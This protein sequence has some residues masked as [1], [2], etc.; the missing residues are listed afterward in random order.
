MSTRFTS[1]AGID[2][3]LEE[4]H[5]LPL[6]D[7][8]VVL[9]RGCRLDPPGLEGLTRLTA[10]MMRRGP[11]GVGAELFD[12][13]LDALGS[14]LATTVA[15]ESTRLSGTVLQRNL[16]PFLRA[17]RDVLTRPALRKADLARLRRRAIA[18]VRGLRDHDRALAARAFRGA[19]FGAH[20]YARP[21]WG[22]EASLARITLDDVRAQHARLVRAGHLWVGFAGAVREGDVRPWVDDALGA[23]P[24]G[25]EPRP[26][27]GAVRRPRGRRVVL[28]D[29]PSRAQTQLYV[30]AL[31]LRAGDPRSTAATVANTGFGGTFTSRLVHEV[32]S[33]RGWSYSASS[34]LGLDRQRD[35]WSMYSH[36]S[37]ELVLDCLALE[38]SLVEGWCARGL[39][40]REVRAAK[41]YL[42][43]SHAFERETAHRRLSVDLEAAVLSL[44]AGWTEA[45][46]ERLR[47]V[48]RRSAHE[49]IRSFLDPDHLT[50]AVLATHTPAL[51][52]GLL[53]LPGVRRVERVPYT[54]L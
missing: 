20:D 31:G 50:V 24:A 34:H 25:A 10:Q 46:D 51:E 36:P 16:T 7:I 4:D 54:A 52:E 18:D 15:H 2:V 35:A 21:V 28:V 43:K 9:S 30:G 33:E 39:S 49:A 17:V 27:G 44:P 13:R 26:K 32:R 8:E 14:S 41:R 1:S 53:A 29:K 12:E 45:F 47:A 6:V 22:T 19:L 37:A 40:A 48:T 23:V 11:R 38:L 3:F 5:A 42:S